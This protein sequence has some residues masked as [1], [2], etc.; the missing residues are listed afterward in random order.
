MSRGAADVRPLSCSQAER[1]RDGRVTRNGPCHPHAAFGH[2]TG[3]WD[4]RR[5]RMGGLLMKLTKPAN[6]HVPSSE[7]RAGPTA[8]VT[9]PG[10]KK[11]Q[12]ADHISLRCGNVVCRRAPYE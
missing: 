2:F 9:L 7:F 1:A 4:D 6:Q 12:P 11:S 3:S 5:S 10:F 8:S